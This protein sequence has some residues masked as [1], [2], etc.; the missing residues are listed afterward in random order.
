MGVRPI[1]RKYN[2]QLEGLSTEWTKLTTQAQSPQA[3]EARKRIA[4]RQV[5]IIDQ[6]LEIFTNL[7]QM[8]CPVTIRGN[9]E[10]G[11]K[12]LRTAY[13]GLCNSQ[14][15]SAGGQRRR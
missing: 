12:A 13:R 15:P 14:P 7:E 5:Q 10:A 4:C 1:R 9:L 6:R 11:Y 8:R 3:D 2:T